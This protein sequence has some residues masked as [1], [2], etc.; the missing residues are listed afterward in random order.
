MSGT[1][2]N[3]D[4]TSYDP[5]SFNASKGGYAQGVAE[6]PVNRPLPSNAALVGDSAQANWIPEQAE[7]E[8]G[9]AF[10]PDIRGA[11][12]S[13]PVQYPDGTNAGNPNQTTPNLGT[14]LPQGTAPASLLPI[15]LVPSGGS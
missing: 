12:M 11:M 1:V 5:P 7:L 8:Y 3:P 9:L 13:Y 14:D 4:G 15:G 6:G 10:Q 2:A